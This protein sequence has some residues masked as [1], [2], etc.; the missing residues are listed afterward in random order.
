MGVHFYGLFGVLLLNDETGAEGTH[1]VA[2]KCR[3]DAKRINLELLRLW[4]GGRGRP[5]SWDVL[6]DVL[7]TT[8]LNTLASDIQD[9]VQ[10]SLSS[11]F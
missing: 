7:K 1:V 5:L 10:H 11:S 6:I 2:T 9:T 3:E 4:I 8:G